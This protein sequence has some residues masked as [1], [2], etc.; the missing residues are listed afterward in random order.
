[1]YVCKT[2]G[3]KTIDMYNAMKDNTYL[4]VS[5]LSCPT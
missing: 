3:V 4:V 5:S 2:D 1:M